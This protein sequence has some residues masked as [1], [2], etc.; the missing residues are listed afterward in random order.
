MSNSFRRLRIF[1]VMFKVL[2]WLVLVLIAVG[3]VG[4][5]L[6][7]NPTVPA[8]PAVLNMVFSGLVGF[9]V[10]HSLGDIIGI[11]LIIEENTRKS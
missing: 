6:S 4:V 1:S 3:A 7:K 8:L 9:L 2:A 11:L 10:M 5:I